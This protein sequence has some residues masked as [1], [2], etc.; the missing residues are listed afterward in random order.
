MPWAGAMLVSCTLVPPQG[1]HFSVVWAWTMLG[2]EHRVDHPITSC[3]HN[4]YISLDAVRKIS[5]GKWR[6]VC[7]SHTKASAME[8]KGLSRVLR[9]SCAEPR[10]EPRAKPSDD[11]KSCNNH[12]S[13]LNHFC[14][15]RFA[16]SSY[17]MSRWLFTRVGVGW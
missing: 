3:L 6:F 11:P 7:N 16:L 14:C 8:A 17:T 5:R 13:K 15:V 12:K 10:A 2:E 9:G 4:A 1:F